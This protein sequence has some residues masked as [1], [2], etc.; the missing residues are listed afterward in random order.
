VLLVSAPFAH[1]HKPSLGL[2]LLKA[3]LELRGIR[4]EIRYYNLSFAALVD[5]HAYERV[6]EGEPS[7]DLLVGEWIFS[8]ALSEATRQ[9]PRAYVDE[10]LLRNQHFLDETELDEEFLTAI[11]DMHVRAVSFVDECVQDV[12]RFQPKVVGLTSLYQQHVC[13]LALA[14]RLKAKSPETFLLMGG[15]ACEGVMGA[16]TL[17]QFEFLD[18]VISGEAEQAFPALV[19]QVLAGETPAAQRGVYLRADLARR[20][21]GQEFENTPMITDLDSLPLVSYEDYFA[22]YDAVAPA[23][24]DQRVPDVL[25]ETSRGCWFGEKSHCTFCGLNGAGMVFRSKSATRA[26]QEIETLSRLHPESTINVVDNILDMRYFK[27]FIPMLGA[28]DRDLHVFYETKS[29]LNRQQVTALKESGIRSI[30]P[31]VESL[32]NDVLKRMRKGVNRLQN[33]Q[34]LKWCLELGVTAYWNFLWGFP[35]ESPED[36]FEMATL[37]PRIVHLPPPYRCGSVRLDRFSPIYEQTEELGL[38]NVRPYPAYT[39]VYPMEDGAI[40]NLAYY[41]THDDEHRIEAASYAHSLLDT[42]TTWREAHEE[43]A[44]ISK[45]KG[46]ELHIWDLRP[47]A[48]RYHYVLDAI[49]RR[50]Y[51]AC[52]ARRSLHRL[53]ELTDEKGAPLG[54]NRVEDLVGP[55]VDSGLVLRDGKQILSLAIPLG[56]YEPASGV[57]ARFFEMALNG[58]GDPV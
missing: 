49:A 1:V 57:M 19:E 55:L 58:V 5:S 38:R 22:Q 37:I 45:V 36:Y 12:L 48:G 29:N 54:V 3:A 52:D 20:F 46:E 14:K 47:G 42:I 44:L 33:V 31:G 2:S 16:E 7:F 27:D 25:F 35:G 6:A 21:A 39:Y 15:V 17:R 41:F 51:E 56:R 26:L 24:T 30:Q 32:S 23:I 10:M 18:A 40:A 9:T 28:L 8:A 11:L 53:A 4:A 34:L 13:S 50:L 43:S